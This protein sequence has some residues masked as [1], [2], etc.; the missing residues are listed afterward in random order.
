MLWNRT[1][2]FKRKIAF[3]IYGDWSSKFVHRLKFRHLKKRNKEK[4]WKNFIFLFFFYLILAFRIHFVTWNIYET[5]MNRKVWICM[6][7]CDF[8]VVHFDECCRDTQKS[9]CKH[10]FTVA[11][12]YYVDVRILVNCSTLKFVFDLY[13]IVEF[14]NFSFEYLNSKKR[15]ESRQTSQLLDKYKV[16]ALKKGSEI[17]AHTHI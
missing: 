2:T 13:I 17:A 11:I 12:Q 9:H 8:Q 15:N 16:P 5:V 4:Q 3:N 14:L 1:S 10:C 7:V 6:Y